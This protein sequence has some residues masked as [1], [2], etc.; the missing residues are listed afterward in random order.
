MKRRWFIHIVVVPNI[1]LCATLYYD[2]PFM[3]QIS[4]IIVNYWLSSRGGIVMS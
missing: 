4:I 2:V 1:I 3:S